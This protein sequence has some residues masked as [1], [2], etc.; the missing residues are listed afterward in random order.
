MDIQIADRVIGPKHP[1]YFI[2]DI[3]A[4]TGEVLKTYDSYEDKSADFAEMFM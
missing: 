4:R 1:V 2:A 3:G